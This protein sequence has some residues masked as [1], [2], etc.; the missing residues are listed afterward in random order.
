MALLDKRGVPA[1][2]GDAAWGRAI[3][4]RGASLALFPAQAVSHRANEHPIRNEVRTAR[5]SYQTPRK[6]SREP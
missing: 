6:V 4:A 2:A 3:A 5:A 1:G